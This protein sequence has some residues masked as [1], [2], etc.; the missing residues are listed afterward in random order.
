MATNTTNFN[1]SLYEGDDY[2]N[3]L[4]HENGNMEKID[5]QMFRNLQASAGAA[6]RTSRTSSAGSACPTSST[7]SSAAA[8]GAAAR[9][10]APRAAT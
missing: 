6:T 9:A 5:A 2:F 8:P 10:S 4:V 1:L 7:R 3:P